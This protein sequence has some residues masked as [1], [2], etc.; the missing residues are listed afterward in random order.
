MLFRMAVLAAADV[1]G[2]CDRR[3]FSWCSSLQ[4]LWVIQLLR[5]DVFLAWS[6]GCSFLAFWCAWTISGLLLMHDCL[7]AE[8]R[9]LLSIRRIKLGACNGSDESVSHYRRLN[10]QGRLTEQG[11]IS[12]GRSLALS[13][14]TIG[15]K[16]QDKETNER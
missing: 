10:A 4:L 9:I 11:N 2:F 7:F 14:L 3:F 5:Y 1:A 12:R 16:Q 6:K 8:R 13:S 15:A